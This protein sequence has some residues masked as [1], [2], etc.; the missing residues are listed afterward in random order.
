MGLFKGLGLLLVLVLLGSRATAKSVSSA[1]GDWSLVTSLLV[2]QV[3]PALKEA[4]AQFDNNILV[5]SLGP[6]AFLLTDAQYHKRVVFN[7]SGSTP[8]VAPSIEFPASA[9]ACL[10][11]DGFG[12]VYNHAEL[13]FVA[14]DGTTR[15]KKAL[16]P[17]LL[18]NA[19]LACDPTQAKPT[20][21][22]G[23]VNSSSNS[24]KPAVPLIFRCF[25]NASTPQLDCRT[26]SY[27][28]RNTGFVWTLDGILTAAA[29]STPFSE[30]SFLLSNQL[31]YPNQPPPPGHS[32]DVG[33]TATCKELQYSSAVF[34]LNSQYAALITATLELYIVQMGPRPIFSNCRVLVHRQLPD[35]IA[36]LS[37]ASIYPLDPSGTLAMLVLQPIDSDCVH[38]YALGFDPSIGDQGIFNLSTGHPLPGV[39][40]ATHVFVPHQKQLLVMGRVLQPQNVLLGHTVPAE[41]QN[42]RDINANTEGKLTPS[43]FSINLQA[44]TASAHSIPNGQSKR[45]HMPSWLCW[46]LS[47]GVMIVL[48]AVV[49]QRAKRKH[50]EAQGDGNSKASKRLPAMPDFMISMV[51]G[52]LTNH[53]TRISESDCVDWSSS[54][55]WMLLLRID[56]K[57]KSDEKRT[58]ARRLLELLKHHLEAQAPL[59]GPLPARLAT[60]LSYLT[61]DEAKALAFT[62]LCH[63]KKKDYE[64]VKDVTRALLQQFVKIPD[65]RSVSDFLLSNNDGEEESCLW[66]RLLQHGFDDL[67]HDVLELLD[68]NKQKQQVEELLSVDSRVS[69]VQKIASSPEEFPLCFRFIVRYGSRINTHRAKLS[70][71]DDNWCEHWTKPLMTDGNRPY[72]MNLCIELV[73]DRDVYPFV[74]MA[75]CIVVFC[76]KR[77]GTKSGPYCSACL[78]TFKDYPDLFKVNLTTAR[79]RYQKRGQRKTGGQASNSTQATP[80]SPMTSSPVP[81]TAL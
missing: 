15:A 6:N 68:S 76:D 42:R 29:F 4:V 9:S 48:V 16:S 74:F 21:I 60:L 20:V 66:I 28:R 77:H 8:L 61:V 78:K 72:I 3:P 10:L 38:L 36:E 46:G 71:I 37:H 34:P 30:S 63:S 47:I 35:D 32:V 12:F 70:A 69:G 50:A 44:Y 59:Q 39:Q 40:L 43:K 14:P 17:S 19:T 1:E 67:A 57:R 62:F 73:K 7:E 81:S 5:Q 52:T 56:D 45:K 23:V 22:V 2:G 18:A 26:S 49:G 80:S 33:P 27:P 58:W 31:L 41:R 51:F 25:Y 79:K 54:D 55:L 75:M 64:L 13:A 11:P 24:R 53:F 65:D